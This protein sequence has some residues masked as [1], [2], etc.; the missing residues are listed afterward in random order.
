MSILTRFET[1]LNEERRKR[2]LPPLSSVPPPSGQQ[3]V[4]PERYKIWTPTEIYAPIPPPEYVI[5]P[6][7]RKANLALVV[8]F[9]SSLKTWAMVNAATAVATG[10]RFLDRFECPV[11]GETLIVDWESGDEEL[12]RRL[13]ADAVARAVPMPVPGVTFVTMPNLFFTSDDFEVEITKLAE[14]KKLVQLDSLAAGST[15]VEE[16][17]ARFAQPLQVMKRVATKTGTSFVLLHHSRKEGPEGVG[18]ERQSVRGSGAIFAAADVV[19]SLRRPK[20]GPD[21]AFEVR[22]TKAR[23]GKAVDPFLLRVEDLEEGGTRTYA[24]ELLGEDDPEL[25]A[26]ET[27]TNL[28]TLERVKAQIIHALAARHDLRSKNGIADVVRARKATFLAAF[29]EL[30]LSQIVVKH[31]GC[32]RLRSEVDR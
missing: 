6:L 22:Q 28:E 25:A 29:G 13:Q 9:G 27:R 19:L 15:D 12:R 23:G 3:V 17:D 4:P 7:L 10:T 11:A 31:E 30:E 1:D 26:Q 8:A 14:G 20:K 2:G 32:F 24:T 16:N 21:G 5:A 18:D